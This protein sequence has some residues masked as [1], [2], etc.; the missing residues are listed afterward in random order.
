MPNPEQKRYYKDLAERLLPGVSSDLSLLEARYPDRELPPDALVTRVAPS[1]TGFMHIGGLYA[2]IVSE[3]L[4]HQSGG[5]FYLRI[6]DTDQKR[7]VE[8]G[9]KTIIRVL[10]DYDVNVDEGVFGDNE[11][12]GAYG[13]YIQSE[14]ADIYKAVIKKM[15]ED[16]LAYPCFCSAEELE[17]LRAEQEAQ[18]LKTGYYGRFAKWRDADMAEVLKRLDNN[19]PWIIRFNSS[20]VAEHP[21]VFE[22]LFK[23][24]KE[25]PANDQDIIILK[26]DG[27]PTY[28]LAHVVDDHF[29]RTTHVTRGD[30]WFASVPLH[31]Q[32]FEALAWPAPRYGHFAP[33]QKLDEGNRR[34]LS[35]RKDPEANAEFYAEAGYP[36]Q[37]V[38]EYL[39]NLANSSF[40]D[41]RRANPGL[42]NRE[43]KLIAKKVAASAGALLDP[44]KLA[45]ISREMIARL[46]NVEVYEAVLAWALRFAP[47]FAVLL[48]SQPDYSKRIFQLERGGEKARK[49]LAKWSDVPAEFGFFFDELFILGKE[50]VLAQL[51]NV[52]A[53]IAKLVANAFLAE[54]DIRDD[55]EA[56]FAKV[57]K[58]AGQF[59]Y[60]A[61]AKEYKQEPDKYRGQV[62]DIARIFRLA[63]VGR[64]QTPD[65][66]ALI[67]ILGEKRVRERLESFTKMI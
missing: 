20:C 2:A 67:N 43:F 53:D 6:E 35:K 48:E 40:E 61:S 47:E 65:L 34:K 19:E 14:R 8:G 11:Q 30:E 27:L 37:A 62:G 52:P 29:M 60:A 58:L 36:V 9:L 22:D 12:K 44:I 10:E 63:L 41:W 50:A 13:P 64:S 38:I 66:H 42:D 18:K 24:R 33:I 26:S 45:D 16:G 7:E 15:L 28:H 23:G 31:L 55:S 4:A 59:G 56:W 5:L 57:K 54:F 25:L 46:S 49:D 39:L 21:V 51:G 3:R 1:P 17:Q 32:L